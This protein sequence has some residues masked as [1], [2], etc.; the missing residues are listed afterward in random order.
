MKRTFDTTWELETISGDWAK[1]PV[2]IE[3]APSQQRV[4]VGM[5]GSSKEIIDAVEDVV[6]SWATEALAIVRDILDECCDDGNLDREATG[7]FYSHIEG[8]I[9]GSFHYYERM[10]GPGKEATE[11]RIKWRS[12]EPGV[13]EVFSFVRVHKSRKTVPVLKKRRIQAVRR[14]K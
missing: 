13:Y 7:A 11:V 14:S 8:S 2:R 12:V 5:P 6:E 4:V 9:P 3:V 1:V 10:R